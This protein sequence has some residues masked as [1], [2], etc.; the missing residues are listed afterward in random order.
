M[1]DRIRT[2]SSENENLAPVR[3][4]SST[5]SDPDNNQEWLL[6]PFSNER[7]GETRDDVPSNVRDQPLP[8]RAEWPLATAADLPPELFGNILFYVDLHHRHLMDSKWRGDIHLRR[9]QEKQD[10]GGILYDLKMCSL[11]CRHWANHCRRYVFLDVTFVISSAEDAEIFKTYA[12]RGCPSLVPVHQLIRRILV[13]QRYDAPRSFCHILHPLRPLMRHNPDIENSELHLIGPIPDNFPKVFLNGPHWSFAPSAITPPSLLQSYHL[14][15]LSDI[16]L[17]SFAHAIRYAR[18]FKYAGSI[19]FAKLTWTTDGSYSLPRFSRAHFHQDQREGFLHVSTVG[20]TDNVRLGMQVAMAHPEIQRWLS[21][22]ARLWVV[23]LVS[24]FKEAYA[25]LQ[26]LN[27]ICRVGRFRHR[28]TLS[29]DSD[30]DS[31]HHIDCVF[32][33]SNLSLPNPI[34]GDSIFGLRVRGDYDDGPTGGIP[35]DLDSLVSHLETHSTPHIVVFSFRSYAQLQMCMKP[36]R[37]MARPHTS[38]ETYVLVCNRTDDSDLG[39]LFPELSIEEG[40]HVRV[41]PVTLAP[42]GQCWS[43]EDDI[44]PSLQHG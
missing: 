19:E 5:P 6:S 41:D 15:R 10:G 43:I 32:T 4:S 28:L 39:Y 8:D 21:A 12:T 1:V 9:R 38:Y 22:D 42:T 31:S 30:D 14:V 33:F 18:H 25:F 37:P 34:P 24:F 13:E 29:L 20:C 11:V 35:L 2:G 7:M 36:F 16:H 26:I 40:A 3:S 23:S 17:P 44:L 27:P